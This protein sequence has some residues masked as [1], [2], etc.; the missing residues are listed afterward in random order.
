MCLHL[1]ASNPVAASQSTSAVSNP[2]DRDTRSQNSKRP[3][4]NFLL[5]FL[6]SLPPCLLLAPPASNKFL[7]FVLR[8]LRIIRNSWEASPKVVQ[9]ECSTQSARPSPF[10]VVPAHSEAAESALAASAHFSHFGTGQCFETRLWPPIGA[11]ELEISLTRVISS[12]SIFLI[13][14]FLPIS[15]PNFSVS[16]FRQICSSLVTCHSSLL[17]NR[18]TKKLKIALSHRKQSLG[19]FLIDNFDA[20]SNLFSAI[21]LPCNALACRCVPSPYIRRVASAAPCL[22]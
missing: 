21:P 12:T 11:Q 20:F 16:R 17:S 4:P 13:D 3:L 5:C 6:A 8:F 14:K 7:P 9:E 2:L 15:H 22:L 19:K 10:R 18:N 1:F